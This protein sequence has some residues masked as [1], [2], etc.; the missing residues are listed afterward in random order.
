MSTIITTKQ[1]IE[2]ATSALLIFQDYQEELRDRHIWFF[3]S[4]I[5]SKAA[6][7]CLN[8]E[9]NAYGVIKDLFAETH[10]EITINVFGKQEKAIEVNG[11]IIFTITS[12]EAKV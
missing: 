10:S 4:Y 6:L 11:V 12:S 8:D 2:R 5:G 7:C 1:L 3:L 9:D